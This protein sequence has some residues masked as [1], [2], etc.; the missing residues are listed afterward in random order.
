MGSSSH[1]WRE[2]VFP[3]L[4]VPFMIVFYLSFVLGLNEAFGNNDRDFG[5]D[6]FLL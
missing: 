2:G 6:T 4:L 5:F 3:L 1:L